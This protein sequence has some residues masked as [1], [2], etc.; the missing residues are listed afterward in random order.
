MVGCA[1]TLWWWYSPKLVALPLYET[2]MDLVSTVAYWSTC[3]GRQ[4]DRQTGDLS[5]QRVRWRRQRKRLP[6]RRWRRQVK[7]DTMQQ[8]TS[9]QK[10]GNA[11]LRSVR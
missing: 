2:M 11:V 7:G 4:A 6:E 8:L 9:T 10:S 3:R 1:R 5:L